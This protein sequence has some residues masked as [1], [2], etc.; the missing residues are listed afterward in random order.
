MNT[1]SDKLQNIK[2][3][4]SPRLKKKIFDGYDY[5]NPVDSPEDALNQALG[6]GQNQR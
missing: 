1:D 6:I 3:S 5:P 4:S 2:F